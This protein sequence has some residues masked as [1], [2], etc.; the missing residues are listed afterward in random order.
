MNFSSAASTARDV[1]AGRESGAVRDAEDVRVDRDG[2][3]TERGVQDHV[4]GL[5]ADARQ[6]FERFARLGHFAAV[7]V[8]QDAAGRDDVLRLGAV[9]ADRL[10][11]ARRRLLR[12]A[13]S[14]CCGV[15]ATGNSLRIALLTDTSVA[16]A[17]SS[18]AIS[19]SNGV[20]YSS[21]VVGCGFRL[22][23]VSKMARRLFAFIP[24]VRWCSDRLRSL[25][26][27]DAMTNCRCRRCQ[28]R[29]GG[30]A[31]RRRRSAPA[32]RR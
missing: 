21:S 27:S 2:R 15:F 18:T 16:C 5:A 28:V 30:G 8:E 26:V 6:R 24:S 14:I 1:L 11:V 32:R 19:S 17:D 31:L 3:M 4:G 13:S 7:L 29:G 9:E 20:V 12:R 10:D 25:V 23:S 22:R